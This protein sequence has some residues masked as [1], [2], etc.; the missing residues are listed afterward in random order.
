MA[1]GV[2]S[3]GA[4]SGAV[5]DP[6]VVSG[7]GITLGRLGILTGAIETLSEG[8]ISTADGGALAGEVDSVGSLAGISDCTETLAG[9][10][11]ALADDI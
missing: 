6:R 1:T 8:G 9:G 5:S 11:A 3:V 7:R 2:L 10:V 4:S